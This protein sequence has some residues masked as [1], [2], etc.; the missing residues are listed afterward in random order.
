MTRFNNYNV[1]ELKV[2][3]KEFLEAFRS[4]ETI[5]NGERIDTRQWT[6][7]FLDWFAN[8]AADGIRVD[9]SAPREASLRGIPISPTL[10][11]IAGKRRETKREFLF[12]LCHSTWLAD[13]TGTK[14]YWQDSLQ[15]RPGPEL[16]LVLESE[17]G[18]ENNRSATLAAVM[19]DAAKLLH[20]V[21]AVKV[22]IFASSAPETN[23]QEI[24]HLASGLK[25]AD[26]PETAW[27]WLDLPWVDTHAG[28]G[29]I[30]HG[31]SANPD[32]VA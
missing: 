18:K 5:L 7:C 20:V 12:D 13:G 31:S 17:M 4:H 28:G 1:R 26:R 16:K 9:G 24:L 19:E 3:G 27:L 23:V 25:A 6:E 22:V 11:K 30:F 29:W 10:R 21:S 2:V 8:T 15:R 14:S 32:K